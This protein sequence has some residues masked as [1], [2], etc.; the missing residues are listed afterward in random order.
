MQNH[1]TAVGS[2]LLWHQKWYDVTK[3]R[4]SGI[5]RHYIIK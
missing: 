2:K 1:V 3:W 5:W 4:H